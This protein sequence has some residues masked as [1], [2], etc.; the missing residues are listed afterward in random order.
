MT[1]I[2]KF[3]NGIIDVSA[4]KKGGAYTVVTTTDSAKTFFI[5]ADTVFTLPAIAIGNIFTFVYAGNNGAAT[6]T[7][8]PNAVDG[9]TYAGSQTDNKDMILTKATAKAGDFVTISSIDQTVAWQ[10]VAVRGVWTKEA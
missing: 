7:L 3:K 8:S 6:L 1:Q 9:I 4:V 10:V 2:T 5:E